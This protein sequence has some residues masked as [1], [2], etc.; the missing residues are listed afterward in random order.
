MRELAPAL[1]RR[2]LAASGAEPERAPPICSAPHAACCAHRKSCGQPPQP[3]TL[4]HSCAARTRSAAI[5]GLTSNH[6]PNGRCEILSGLMGGHRRVTAGRHQG[7]CERMRW[8]LQ[9]ELRGCA[10]SSHGS[11]R[12]HS[13]PAGPRFTVRTRSPRVATISIQGWCELDLRLVKTQPRVDANC[14]DGSDVPHPSLP[15]PSRMAGTHS[16]QRPPIPV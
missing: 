8:P 1:R 14:I 3:K 9:M 5:L 10:A 12:W 2:Q 6:T 16:P 15:R 11:L 13:R 4:R 7:W